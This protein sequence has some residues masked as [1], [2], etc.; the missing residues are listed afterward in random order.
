MNTGAGQGMA[1]A[2]ANQMSDAQLLAIIATVAA[3][4]L[5]GVFVVWRIKN[6]HKDKKKVLKA[7]VLTTFY[8]IFSKIPVTR[9]YAGKCFNKLKALSVQTRVELKEDASIATL[10]GV[11]SCVLVAVGGMFIV[12]DLLCRILL[13]ILGFMVANQT[14]SRRIQNINLKV[15]YK[16]SGYIGI[17]REEF[18]RRGNIPDALEYAE[19]PAIL[20]TSISQ[21]RDIMAS[22][23]IE[24]E[25]NKF[26]EKSSCDYIKTF[27]I[28]CIKI[29]D[30]GEDTTDDKIDPTFIQVLKYLEEDVNAEI[31]RRTYSKRKFGHLEKTSLVPLFAVELLPS[32]LSGSMPGLN[33]VYEGMSGYI[34][35]VLITLACVGGYYVI[36]VLSNVDGVEIDDRSAIAERLCKHRAIAHIAES[37]APKKKHKV[38]VSRLLRKSISNKTLRSLTLERILYAIGGFILTLAIGFAA[39][40]VQKS[41]AENST[42]TFGLIAADDTAAWTKEYILDADNAILADMA[43]KAQGDPTIEAE[44]LI[45]DAELHDRLAERFSGLSEIQLDDQVTRIKTKYNLINTGYFHW[46]FVVI[47]YGAA[48]LAFFIPIFKLKFRA[49]SIRKQEEEEF[50]SLQTLCT[51]IAISDADVLDALESMYKMAK[52]YKRHLMYAYLNYSMDPHRELER[53]SS[54]LESVDFKRMIKKLQLAVEDVT[55]KEAFEGMEIERKHIVT[56]REQQAISIIDSRRSKAGIASKVS[57]ALLIVGLLVFPIVYVGFTEL[58]KVFD[59]LET[60]G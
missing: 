21:I 42:N 49:W 15:L 41:Y 5:A 48:V 33:M 12:E 50:L 30:L 52:L 47:A 13:F 60:L 22:A 3:V 14:L 37:A 38:K 34:I 9:K 8:N 6:M 24:H 57:M 39:G 19:C 44:D 45:T 26:L 59:G 20:K 4:L 58:L 28:A 51:I 11:A 17:V 18:L 53:L 32:I 31:E 1:D 55:L 7:K 23:D 43:A 10:I 2:T 54:R 25:L 46:Y 40:E 56:M 36:T 29:N 35:K 16:L 27:A